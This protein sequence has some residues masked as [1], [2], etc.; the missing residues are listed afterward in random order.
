MLWFISCLG[1][2][3]VVSVGLCLKL[4]LRFCVSSK[5]FLASDVCDLVIEISKCYFCLTDF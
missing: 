5:L 2:L 4:D 1:R 3:A